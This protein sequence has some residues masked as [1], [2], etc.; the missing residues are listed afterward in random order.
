MIASKLLVVAGFVAN[1][2]LALS[3]KNVALYWG[4][5]SYGDQDK[6]S[7]YCESD[8]FDVVI[9]SFVNDFP[10]L[11]LNLAN[12]CGNTFSDGLLHCSAVGEDIKTCQAKGKKVLLSL[13]GAAGNY[14]FSSDAE[15]AAFATTL[16]N[17]FGG[18]SDD[19]R[20]FDDAV[21][22]GFDLDLEK[23]NQVGTVAFANAL[24]AHFSADSSK[25]YYLSASPQCPYP[26]ASVG[27]VLANVPLDYAFV[28][29]YNNQ[30]GLDATFNWNTWASFAAS[31]PNPDI[32]LFVGLPGGPGS[33][34]SG[35]VGL[36]TVKKQIT[37]DVLC[38][39]NFGGFSLWDA[40]SAT[41]NVNLNGDNFYVQLND[42]LA[43]ATC[44]TSS[45][46]SS[47]SA[48]TSSSSSTSVAATVA[49]SVATSAAPLALYS[50]STSSSV[51]QATVVKTTVIEEIYTTVCPDDNGVL[52]TI[53]AT[54][55]KTVTFTGEC[56]CTK[57]GNKN[58]VA[59]AT[60]TTKATGA[61]TGAATGATG[62][63][64]A[65]AV[66]TKVAVTGSAEQDTTITVLYTQTAAGN[67][68]KPAQISS[69][70]YSG[71]SSKAGVS[72]F[73]VLML[74]L[75]QLF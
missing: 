65:T 4:Q 45:S 52:T 23:Q 74:S 28:Q 71:S 55:I 59:P 22:D 6:L 57:G 8:D 58:G 36:D 50:N 54:N 43:G 9:V 56:E 29:F 25:S 31:A 37:Q 12:Q 44:P 70:E 33:A 20:P 10:K 62:A 27:D 16:W 21:V 1:Q 61:T 64:A 17:K 41:N 24:R 39:K 63:S 68:T 13:G 32:Q 35:F 69:Y 18:G 3:N 26:D 48:A 2:V 47:T 5:N 34:V 38:S 42:F 14:G 46:S 7:T 30:C 11:G 60:E 49:T 19:E 73:V 53:V 15:G 66:T 67:G 72:L 75:L 51:D 40:S